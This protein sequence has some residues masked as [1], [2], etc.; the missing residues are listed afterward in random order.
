[1]PIRLAC[2]RCHDLKVRCIQNNGRSSCK[3]CHAAATACKYSESMRGLRPKR[4]LRTVGTPVHALETSSS[5]Q[6]PTA[7]DTTF[8]PI[9]GTGQMD[10][11][12]SG[13]NLQADIF[14]LSQIFEYPFNPNANAVVEMPRG[15][16]TS[17]SVLA[18]MLP[19]PRSTI[20]A[21]EQ[22]LNQLSQ[23]LY[24]YMAKVPSIEESHA[25]HQHHEPNGLHFDEVFRLTESAVDVANE[26]T[27]ILRDDRH[28]TG[29]TTGT[30]SMGMA[31]LYSF[32]SCQTRLLEIWAVAFCCIRGCVEKL[33]EIS[34]D[35]DQSIVI[36]VPNVRIGTFTPS[37]MTALNLHLSL[38]VHGTTELRQTVRAL[39]EEIS[40]PCQPFLAPGST[41]VGDIRGSLGV[42]ACSDLL[43]RATATALNSAD[44]KTLVERAVKR[45]QGRFIAA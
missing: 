21:F 3:R 13:F 38:I 45:T 23:Q 41:I 17:S 42:S 31:S 37:I 10:F 16:L 30:P 15:E 27:K 24:E 6:P 4:S 28:L 33:Q 18:D 44:L 40:V 34:S 43:E 29:C 2:D 20:L 11:D 5:S 32:L 25:S 26:F 12:D 36:C 39:V 19:E 1:M 35:P 7:A 8:E 22:G 9:D 14:N